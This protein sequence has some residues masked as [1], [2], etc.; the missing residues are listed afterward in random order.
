MR[1]GPLVT[2]F[3]PAYNHE[4]YMDDY[5]GG[6]LAQTYENVELIVFDDGST[7]G[8]WRRLQEAEP[9]LR[10]KFAH[11]VIE[12]HEN[13]GASQET[14]LGLERAGGELI[15]QLESDD[16]YLPRKLE[17]NVRYLQRH[18]EVGAVHSDV[19]FVY[20]RRIEAAHW[21]TTGLSIPT[22][23]IFEDLL[24]ENFV[25]MCSFCC[26]TDL[27]RRHA[28]LPGYLERG[29][30]APDYAIFLDLA[31]ETG[32][33][34]IDESLVRYRA[35]SG[36]LSHPIDSGRLF[37]FQRSIYAMKLDLAREHEASPEVTALVER[38]YHTYLYRGGVRACQQ[39]EALEGYR[40]LRSHHP[41][42]HRFPADLVRRA[43]I[44]SPLLCRLAQ[45]LRT[46]AIGAVSRA[47]RRPPS[48]IEAA[49]ANLP[50]VALA[51]GDGRTRR[52]FGGRSRHLLRLQRG[53]SK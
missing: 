9:A 49:R 40:W 17:A 30:L 15:C 31:A 39:A 37:A 53:R 33:G 48:V 50:A 10:G 20:G 8:T 36:S 1:D 6:L 52:L 25:L 41:A 22:G 12:R 42:E 23:N 4:R 45:R 43:L 26:R 7:D 46:L 51:H 32:F 16:Y 47:V 11:V 29:Y 5:L 13:I 2:V 38:Q 19:D 34:Y 28:D 14:I 21:R 24:L 27:M 35:V 18:P 44:A 3:T